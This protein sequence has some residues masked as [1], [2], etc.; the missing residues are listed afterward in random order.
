VLTLQA[1]YETHIDGHEPNL[2]G[3]PREKNSK[4]NRKD[5][6][7]CMQSHRAFKLE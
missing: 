3:K 4:T 6:S 2:A 7:I 1:S 5:L